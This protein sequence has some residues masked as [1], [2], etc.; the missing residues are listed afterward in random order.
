MFTLL[1]LI[2]PHNNPNRH[3]FNRFW[4]FPFGVKSYYSREPILTLI[5]I[6]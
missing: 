2:Y 3:H 4:P 5:E 6:K 1:G